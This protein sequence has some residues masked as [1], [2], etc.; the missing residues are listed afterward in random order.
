MQK[1]H[2]FQF[3]LRT[4]LVVT[5]VLGLACGWL[6]NNAERKRRERDA[7]AA[8]QKVGGSA[9]YDYQHNVEYQD[10][11]PSATPPGPEW[12]RRLLG[13]NFFCKVDSA[14]LVRSSVS[15]ADIEN[16]ATLA[17]L[18]VLM[19]EGANVGDTQLERLKGLTQLKGLNLQGT[20]VGDAAMKYIGGMNHLKSLDLLGTNVTDAG[21]AQLDGLTKLEYLELSCTK[22]TN[23]G[24]VHLA[25]MTQ[26]HNLGLT[27]TTVSDAGLINVQRLRQLQELGLGRTKATAAGE[28]ELLKA[29]PNCRINHL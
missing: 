12:L 27:A 21:L 4:L 7:V 5:V 14:Y 13:D 19:L 6:A 24:L 23:A 26:L 3:S 9:F 11:P 20:K 10:V 25:G 17:D 29:S 15:D 22:V 28:S 8:I 18:K 16:L 2:W 1:L